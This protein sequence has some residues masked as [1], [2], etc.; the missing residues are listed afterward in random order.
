VLLANQAGQG[1]LR[2]YWQCSCK[3]FA[4]GRL[5]CGG[6]SMEYGCP[7]TFDGSADSVTMRNVYERWG[8]ALTAD[9]RMACG[10]ST[11]AWCWN[12]EVD[13]I[14]DLYN[15]YNAYV[16]DAFVLGLRRYHS[17]VVPVCITLG[18]ASVT[19]TPLW[20]LTFTNVPNS[21]GTR[22]Y[23][24]QYISNFESTPTA[25]PLRESVDALPV[26]ELIPMPLPP[27]LDQIKFKQEGDW[28]ISPQ[29]VRGRGAAVRVNTLSGAVYT[30][31]EA[32]GF[33]KGQA[34]S[35]QEYI[36]RA[37]R[38][39][40]E[41]GWQEKLTAEPMGISTRIQ[42]VPVKG[43]SGELQEVQKNVLITFR[44]VIEV[45]GRPVNVLG[46]GGVMTVQLNND[47]SLL[48][49]A[50]VWRTVAKEG[51][52]LPVKPYEQALEEALR[53]IQTPDAYRLESWSWGY[54][55]MAGNMEQK[56]MRIVYEFQFVPTDHEKL[57]DYPPVT[58]EIVGQE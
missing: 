14:W 44:R 53:Q 56:E 32:A 25:P 1:L 55:E 45:G 7:Q 8:P 3:V 11:E 48:N 29:Q 26:L 19:D 2:Y 4:H 31:G 40:E 18:G 36:D 24:L 38:Y 50:K 28:L 43:E 27:A 10:S 37:L 15:N 54:Q 42:S 58:V 13:A 6:S 34:L 52:V 9:L 33:A 51:K 57:V 47:G 12:G 22:F 49:A 21:S 23:H 20:D 17:N 39:L 5:N 30:Q 46:A 41:Q 16:S 35:E